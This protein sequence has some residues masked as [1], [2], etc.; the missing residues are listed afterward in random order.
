MPSLSASDIATVVRVIQHL[1]Q[2]PDDIHTPGLEALCHFITHHGGRVPIKEVNTHAAEPSHHASHE[3]DASEPDEERWTQDTIQAAFDV[4]S[5]G[6]NNEADEE[7]AMELKGIAAEL[8]SE[9]KLDEAIEKL[10]AALRLVPNKAMYWAL[11]ADYFLQLKKPNAAIA[12][13][14]RALSINDQN[15]RAL[16]VRGVAKRHLGQWEESAKDLNDAQTIDFNEDVQV[17]L[18]TVQPKANAKRD[19]RRKREHDEL[20][21]RQEELRRQRQREMEEEEAAKHQ[22]SS[23]QSSGFPGAGGMPGGFPGA[24]GMPGGIPPGMEQLFSDPEIMAALQDPEVAPKLA[25][26]M[27]NPAAAMQMMGDPKMGPIIQKIMAKM[28]GGA[29]GMPGGM[30]GMGGAGMGGMPRPG[31][32]GG[33]RPGGFGGARPSGGAASQ[34]KPAAHNDDLD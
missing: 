22:E 20:H 18:K 1:E 3:D 24:G 7:N 9:G 19:A 27:S 26:L 4:P 25:T 28:M 14:T 31:G 29:G 15:A 6:S 5:G 11:R 17:L 32:F 30:P 33:P 13:A 10:T 23:H 34:P 2:H 8:A 12:D 16:R 21:A